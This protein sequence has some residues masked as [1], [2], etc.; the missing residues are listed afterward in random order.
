M[1][2]HHKPNPGRRDLLKAA[3]GVALLSVLALTVKGVA[4]DGKRSKIGIIGSGHVGS[5]LG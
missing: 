3:G 1:P 4:A 2:R 5:A